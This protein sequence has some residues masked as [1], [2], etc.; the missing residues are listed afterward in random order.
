MA[1]EAQAPAA[2][3][4][5]SEAPADIEG[6]NYE[7]IRARLVEQGR[8]LRKRAEELNKKRKETFGGTELTVAANERIRTEHNCVPIDIVEI[9]GMLLLGY[10]VFIGLKSETTVGDVFSLHHFKKKDDGGLD[11][12]AAGL[13]ALGG[14]LLDPQFQKDFTNL[15]KYTKEAR[16]HALRATDTQL[17]AV[18][19][20]GA[21]VAEIK[22][23]KW[24]I[25]AS[26]KIVYIDDR[27]DR[28]F[29]FPPSHEFKWQL[30]DIN[31]QEEGRHINLKDKVFVSNLGGTLRVAVED[32]TPAGRKIFAE[33]LDDRNQGISDLQLE[34][35]WVGPLLLLKVLPYREQVHRY[36]VVNTKT[37]KA[38]RIDAIGLACQEL[39]EDHGI[40]FPGGY[41]LETGDF[42]LFE[43]ETTD[44]LF[45]RKILSPNGEDVL[46][47]YFR[48][49]DG[50]YVLFSYNLIRKEVATPIHCH[51]YSLFDDGMMM[52]FR[53]LSDEPTRVHPMQVWQTPF[54]SA[55]RAAAAPTDGSF[56]A[57]VGNAELVRGI[58]DALSICRLVENAEPSRQIFEDLIASSARAVTNYYWIDKKE[59][60]DLKSVLDGIHQ[61]SELII[62]EF[63]KVVAF[64][65]QAQAALDDSEE[66][67]N[68]INRDVRTEH[69]KRV[70]PFLDALTS[71]RTLR[72]H[73]ITLREMRYMDLARLSAIEQKAVGRFD[74]VSKDCVAFLLKAEALKPLV[75]ELEAT[76]GKLGEAQKVAD[77][78][79]LKKRL[80][81]TAEGL[82]LLS[83]VVANLKID[84]ATQRTKILEGISVVFAQLNR[85]RA[86]VE[87]KRKE[88]LSHEGKAEF[89]AQ[90]AVLG[91]SVSSA[92]AVCDTPEKCD[93]Q[94]SRL[95]VQL[96]EL[97][98]RFSEF[99]EFLA[100]MSQKREEIYDALSSKKQQL[101][102]E[103][104]RRITNLA[105]AADRILEGIGRRARAMKSADELNAYFA[106]DAMVQK[107]R[108]LCEELAALGDS[109]KA[110]GY[111]SKL[112][113]AR[114]DA[115]RGL[116]D[117]LELFE[118]G[119]NLI[120]LG[121]HR[122]SVNTQPLDLTM[123]PRDG[124]MCIHLSGTDF[125]EAID[126]AKFLETERFWQQTL[127]SE[128]DAVYRGEYLAFAV[129]SDAQLGKNGQSM[130]K[131]HDHLRSNTLVEVTRGY[132]QERYD[133]GY[134][135]G[136]HDADAA[137][138]LEK[139]INLHDAAG[140]L[141]YAPSPRALAAFFWDHAVAD[142]LPAKKARWHL[143]AKSLGRLRASLGKSGVHAA[144]AAEVAAGLVDFVASLGLQEVWAEPDAR[145]A[146][147]YLL[148]ELC[149][150]Q[151]Q[152]AQTAEA[153]QIKAGLLRHID[154]H[155]NRR[156]FDD[157]LRAL[158]GDLRERFT[159]MK[160]WV[161]G[162][163]DAAPERQQQR[164]LTI[165]TAA[166]LC[167]N[168]LHREPSK[169]L[170]DVEVSGLLGQHKRIEHG[171]MRIRI[172]EF[173]ARLGHFH[174]RDVPAYREY[175]K[176]RHE[177]L[178]RD[179]R[180]LRLDEFMPKVMTSFVRNKLI[181]DVYLPL[182]G[183]N[184]AKQL[185]AAGDAK[186]TDL[187]G[188]L[189]LV[190]P[191]GYGK[192]TLM[193]YVAN[194]LG[195][196]FMKVN[197]PALGHSVKSIDPAEA[198]N[199]TARQE[200][201]K[202]N[203]AFEMGNNV[204]LYLDDIQHTNTELLQKFISLCDAQRRIEGVWKGNTRTY[205][206]RGKKFC[207][208][209]AGNPYT[210]SGEKFQIPDMLANRADTYNLGDILE[211]KDEA[212]ALSYIENA[213]TSNLVL[214]PLATRDQGD[215]YK[216]IRMAKGE[217]VP[218][219]D[220]THGYSA[221]ELNEITT[222]LKHLFK[223][224]ET[225]LKV[226]LMYIESASQ[227]D[228]FRTEPPFKL[229]GSYRNMNRMAEKVVSAMNDAELEALVT[230]HYQ[231]ESQTLTTGAEANL[232]KLAE[233]RGTQSDEQKARWEAIKG[234]YQRHKR[235]GGNADDPV[236]RLT[237]SLGGLSED[238]TGIKK[239]LETGSG[240]GLERVVRALGAQ[241]GF[242]RVALENG[243]QGNGLDKKLEDVTERLD[244]IRE[245]LA[246]AAA[247]L[248]KAPPP[249]AQLAPPPPQ[250]PITSPEIQL[251]LKQQAD[252][253]ENGLLPM[254]QQ[255]ALRL[256]DSEQV[257]RTLG[258]VRMLL[259]SQRQ[260]P[261]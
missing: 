165:E 18:F 180:R 201:E 103:R 248:A 106:S 235:S 138:I 127:V 187:M 255:A 239:A 162:Y 213:L 45:T 102:D 188:L 136:L 10:S 178:E 150:E 156:A 241:L 206:M 113:T 177:L 105:S 100:D 202:I 15:Y 231:G 143:Q 249:P 148:E 77:V 68:V 107:V 53:A 157:D 152:F 183:D 218:T 112:K 84:D 115:L 243:A 71:L 175:R 216:L 252:L 173:L 174:N 26:G 90:F 251:L 204:M 44:L 36:V 164:F 257:M 111:Q 9:N 81:A 95:L 228:R 29:S 260:A 20:V 116:R 189:L 259:M 37:E 200:V 60:L 179:K 205:D 149:D 33:P 140:L 247:A 121:K 64:K 190:S 7:V 23:F 14:F 221:V 2:A 212:F 49:R 135:R 245:T 181:N 151:P 203:L 59:A 129:L 122:F 169:A 73:C 61:T 46:Y 134:D 97:E 56:L 110:D 41:Y 28:D 27:G 13:E 94:L 145:L 42:K 220:L 58:S 99:D 158:A 22:V 40:I 89:A 66:R 98:G 86:T 92:L 125:Y 209:M 258:E 126:D 230:N 223:V 16:L 168:K 225:L 43:G 32:N 130:A 250:S 237:G 256:H 57:N 39:P 238:L 132:A 199:A 234:E 186:R 87:N 219:T 196:V 48:H 109:V 79:P 52:V 261:R 192:T 108:S 153:E 233:L 198:P 146:A 137:A 166:L 4:Q 227:D 85:S 253:I 167:D 54:M 131:L 21:T 217:E 155:G 55:E 123:V 101:L 83:E 19:Q 51:G 222:V 24:R 242:I 211:G 47:I 119:D 194:R 1:Q 91:Q 3:V 30:P 214:A 124:V 160:A 11:C 208:V 117:K 25:E 38:V 8:E 244:G 182:V 226:N 104:Q 114:Q 78:T 191:P 142:G 65:H 236:S 193:E 207:V 34:F 161:E 76:V 176:L 197:G 70:E 82:N 133:E 75:V 72:G 120:K 128:N 246:G 12:S 17:L 96:E 62:D 159:L 80:D 118:G 210:E 229:Q 195:L 141:R 224:Q 184:M 74:E 171:K 170:S 88:L 67:F 144:L 163:L 254:V 172:D 139:L 69:F 5:A 147:E 185:G 31:D 50:H 6:G 154:L 240:K 215:V 63:E 93:E 35:A 232:L